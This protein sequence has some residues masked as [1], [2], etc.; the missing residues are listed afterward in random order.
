MALVAN[1]AE[2]R[3]VRDVIADFRS[4]KAPKFTAFHSQLS[5]AN[6]H[7]PVS[8]RDPDGEIVRFGLIIMRFGA[9]VVGFGGEIM[10][11]HSF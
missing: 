4:Q 9:R 11:I 8:M 10:G 2:D 3:P 7:A 6:D 1:R 5:G